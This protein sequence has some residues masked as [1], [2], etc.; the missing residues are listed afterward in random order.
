M[1][2]LELELS[3]DIDDLHAGLL[4]DVDD[5]SPIDATELLEENIEENITE[6]VEQL[7]YQAWRQTRE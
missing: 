7:I 5:S 4:E 6:T 2:T 3:V 1:E